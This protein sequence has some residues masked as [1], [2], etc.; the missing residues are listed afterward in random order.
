MRGWHLQ[1]S[2]DT[3]AL[4]E[5]KVFTVWHVLQDMPCM[6]EWYKLAQPEDC[7]TR[8]AFTR[9]S[10]AGTSV[11]PPP[12][13]IIDHRMVIECENRALSAGTERL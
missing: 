11:P 9:I 3:P 5:L 4:S 8:V 13:N 6:C 12:Q 1:G 7:A 2:A 10:M